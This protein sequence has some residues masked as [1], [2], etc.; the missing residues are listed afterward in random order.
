MADESKHEG[1]NVV[2][3]VTEDKDYESGFAPTIV[4][5]MLGS[6]NFE[7]AQSADVLSLKIQSPD[8]RSDILEE[9]SKNIRPDSLESIHILLKSSSVSSLF[10][11]S[12]LEA[13]YDGIIPGKEVIVHVMPQSAVLA[14]DM[15]VQPAD[16]DS[17][18]MGLVMSGLMLRCE[19]AHEGSWVLTAIKPG[20]ELD[21]E[22]EDGEEDEVER[23][24][25]EAE[26]QEEQEFLDL[27]A[28]EAEN[29]S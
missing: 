12:I 17:I 9:A 29:D 4:V 23:E 1:D 6:M 16:V 10:D 18:R 5:V 15:P 24:L 14:D 21:D 8:E 13:F 26:K 19:E 22:E 7:P 2:A 28:K 3:E 27:V 20:G 25:T 11:N